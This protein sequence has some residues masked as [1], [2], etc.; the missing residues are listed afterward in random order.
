[1]AV[2][3]LV[4]VPHARAVLKKLVPLLKPGG[5]IGLEEPDCEASTN[6]YGPVTPGLYKVS[7]AWYKIMRSRHG[8]P[9]IGSALKNEL[10]ANITVQWD[11]IE[12][13]VLHVP[14]NGQSEGKTLYRTTR[15][16]F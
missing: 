6:K 7:R 11:R 9:S 2:L 15:L 13:K 4:Q 16:N 1:M 14:F 5:W 12:E 10:E 3:N 8:D